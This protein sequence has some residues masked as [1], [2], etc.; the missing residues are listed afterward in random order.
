[1]DRLL[2]STGVV[3]AAQLKIDVSGSSVQTPSTGLVTIKLIDSSTGVMQSAGT[4][5]WVK[6]GNNLVLSNPD[7]VNSWATANGGTAD[8]MEYEL[9]PFAVNQSQG[10]NTLQVGANYEGTTYAVSTT[11]WHGG[12]NGGGCG[13]YACMEQ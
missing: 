2:K 12:G 4:F 7:A 13:Q 11:T 8:S 9:H 3:D 10:T 1:M 5:P 6:S